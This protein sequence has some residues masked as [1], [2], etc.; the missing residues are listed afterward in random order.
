MSGHEPKGS[1]VTSEQVERHYQRLRGEA[2]AGGYYLNPDAD[3]VRMLARGLLVNTERHG[4]QA[5][6]CRLTAGVRSEDRDIICPCDYRD[7]DLDEHGTCYCGLYVSGA[8][9]RGERAAGS[10][11]ERRLPA[12]QRKPGPAPAR[13]CG[14]AGSQASPEAGLAYPVWRCQVCGY[15]CARN[16]PPE[17]C[18]ICRAGRDR[19]ERFL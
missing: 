7:A 3:F 10:I 5:C 1:D 4:Y 9:A 14:G 19:F 16:G 11:P 6:P 17:A 2:E 13:A 15:L 8:V 12:D 18:P